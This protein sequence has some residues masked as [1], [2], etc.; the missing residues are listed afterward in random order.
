MRILVVGNGGRE[1]ALLH[2]LKQ[3]APDAEFFIT[4]GNGGTA[5]LAAGVL[6]WMAGHPPEALSDAVGQARHRDRVVRLG[7]VDDDERAPRR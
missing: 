6:D 2:K 3:D 7:W 4:R 5:D 1:H